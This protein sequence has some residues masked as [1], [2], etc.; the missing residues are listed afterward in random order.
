MT[1]GSTEHDL[2]ESFGMAQVRDQ[3]IHDQHWPTSP[4]LQQWQMMA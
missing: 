3:L 4:E 1:F 2:L